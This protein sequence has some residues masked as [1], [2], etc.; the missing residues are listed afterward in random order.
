MIQIRK[1]KNRRQKSSVTRFP[2]LAHPCQHLERANAG[3]TPSCLFMSTQLSVRY[4][5]APDSPAAVGYV[6]ASEF[7]GQ[8]VHI[9]SLDAIIERLSP[10]RAILC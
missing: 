2:Y 9:C 6:Y 4:S 7:D 8:L 3:K 5:E 1:K 10:L